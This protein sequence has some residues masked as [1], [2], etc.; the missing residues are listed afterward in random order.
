MR[1]DDKKMH[2]NNQLQMNRSWF[3][4]GGTNFQGTVHGEYGGEFSEF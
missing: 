4:I 3:K 2:S 1:K